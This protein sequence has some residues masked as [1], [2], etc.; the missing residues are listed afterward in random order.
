MNVYELIQE[1]SKA[2]PDDVVLF[3]VNMDVL[4][5]TNKKTIL[6]ANISGNSEIADIHIKDSKVLI[7][8]SF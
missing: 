8:L 5:T 2:N 4:M 1:L 6:E 3:N 7:D